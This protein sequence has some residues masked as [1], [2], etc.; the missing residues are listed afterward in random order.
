MNNK[1]ISLSNKQESFIKLRAEGTSYD[2]ISRLINV[3][4]PTLI[5]WSK[6]FNIDL[7]NLSEIYKE[8][9]REQYAI[10][11][12]NRIANLS[13]QYKKMHEELLKRDLSSIP[14]HQLLNSVLK[15]DERLSF[16]SDDKIKFTLESNDIF[17]IDSTTKET[18]DG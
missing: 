13:E 11:K 16:E 14:T 5:R 1:D 8:S 7:M 12:V 17:Q 18:W 9:L 6:Q 4:K 2:S 15:I 10:T 3:S